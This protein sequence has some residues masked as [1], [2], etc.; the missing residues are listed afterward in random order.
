MVTQRNSD[1][2][3]LGKRFVFD[4]LSAIPASADPKSEDVPGQFEASQH[5]QGI[6]EKF[7]IFESDAL[8]WMVRKVACNTCD[9]AD[10]TL[11][12]DLN[13]RVDL[14]DLEVRTLLSS[15]HWKD[16]NKVLMKYDQV[17]INYLTFVRPRSS[18]FS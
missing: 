15:E 6:Q 14:P 8:F 4:S 18:L 16:C 11:Q 10:N 1:Y 17:S 2:H 3:N 13:Y 12:G 9:Y 7:S 5:A